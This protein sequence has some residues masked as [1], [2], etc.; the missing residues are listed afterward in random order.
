[1]SQEPYRIDVHH[2]ILPPEYVEAAG[3]HGHSGGGDVAFPRWAV[4]EQL[5]F[6]D[7]AGIAT[8]ITSVSAP[9]VSFGDRD[10]ARRL[11]RRVNEIQARLTAD[12]P[13]RIGAFATLPVPDIDGSLD[14]LAY[15]FDTLKMDGVVLLASTGDTYLGDPSLDPLFAELDRRKA[16]AFVHPNIP[17]TSRGLKLSVPAALIEFVFDTTRAAVNLIFGGAMDRYPN[18]KIIL[19]HAG[20]TI[21]FLAGRLASSRVIPAL[22]ARTP[23]GAL[24][25]LKRFYYDTAISG[26]STTLGSLRE[27]V[28]PSHVL[29]GS[30]YP[31]LPEPLLHE[32]LAGIAGFRGWSDADRRLVERESALALFPRLR[33]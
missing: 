32:N 4:E 8:A 5:A 25:Y 11:A 3:R 29:F 21:P 24:S 19:S 15:A 16:V 26:S 17:S 27:L 12:H 2:H 7:R 22:A 13:T 33:G 23:G 6:M 18:V 20:G 9:G 28:D 31:F 30:D 10:E 14:E 1:M